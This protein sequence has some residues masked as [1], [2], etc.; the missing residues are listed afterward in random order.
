MTQLNA[1]PPRRA[2]IFFFFLCLCERFEDITKVR[3]W[4]R[5]N[6]FCQSSNPILICCTNLHTVAV[7][8]KIFVTSM[9]RS[10]S[11][12]SSLFSQ[13]INY[14]SRTGGENCQMSNS[15]NR[16]GLICPWFV[17]KKEIYLW[18]CNLNIGFICDFICLIYAKYD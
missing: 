13:I 9:S 5:Y 4:A 14:K 17:W 18:S 12:E 2:S 6:Y 3:K 15:T 8:G 11:V 7:L 10:F 16:V 1:N